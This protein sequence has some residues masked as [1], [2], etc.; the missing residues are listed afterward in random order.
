MMEPN[1]TPLSPY[2]FSTYNLRDR[3]IKHLG[4]LHRATIRATTG[5]PRHTRVD[6]LEKA[7][8]LPLLLIIVQETKLRQRQRPDF[9]PQEKAI[10]KWDHRNS[11]TDISDVPP[12]LPPWKRAAL[13]LL[14]RRPIAR[15]R[16]TVRERYTAQ[17][18]H[19]KRLEV[20]YLY[21]C[22]YRRPNPEWNSAD[23]Q[24][25]WPYLRC[26]TIC[27]SWSTPTNSHL[28]EI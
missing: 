3:H 8:P 25:V 5:L 14:H 23:H 10:Q 27:H 2:D 21:R 6:L 22:S 11:H 18:A 16:K 20:R 28:P 4:V 26:R 19:D 15:R 1:S 13:G 17:L 9:T 24:H 12:A 7:A